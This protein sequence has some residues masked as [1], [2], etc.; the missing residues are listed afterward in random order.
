M[1]RSWAQ[2]D[3]IDTF[4][5][6]GFL[7][8]AGTV[9]E[10][11]PF[12]PPDLVAEGLAVPVAQRYDPHPMYAYHRIKPLVTRLFPAGLRAGL[13]VRKRYNVTALARSIAGPVGRASVS[14]S[15]AAGRPSGRVLHGPGD[16]VDGGGGGVVAGRGRGARVPVQRVSW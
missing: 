2:A 9:P 1:R 3:R 15:W 6:R 12:L 7:L 11:S 5:P 8:S 10:G 4:W 16:R 14:G 13:P